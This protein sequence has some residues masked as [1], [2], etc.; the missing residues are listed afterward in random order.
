MKPKLYIVTGNPMKFNEL[1]LPL[2]EFFDCEQRHWDEPEIQGTSEE[3]LKHKLI[4]AYKKFNHPVLVD[5][6]SFHFYDLGGFPGPYIKYFIEALPLYDMGVKFAG[7]RAKVVCWLGLAFNEND[8]FIIDG[9][10]EG[11]VVKPKNKDDQS[12]YFDLFFQVD[13]TDKPMIEYSIQEKNT[14]SHRG[15][16]MK[17]LLDALRSRS[18]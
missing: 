15:V 5:D 6:G 1:S 12:R 14:F 13:G 7:T 8:M 4:N 17:K 9:V 10:V 3:I 2:S 18:R 16:A 11:D